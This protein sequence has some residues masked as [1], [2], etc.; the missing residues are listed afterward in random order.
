M[1]KPNFEEADGLGTSFTSLAC[2]FVITS[3]FVKNNLVGENSGFVF[4]EVN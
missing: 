4:R 3:F 2:L 1:L